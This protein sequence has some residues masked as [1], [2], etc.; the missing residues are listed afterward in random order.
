MVS[1]EIPDWLGCPLCHGHLEY[2]QPDRLICPIDDLVFPIKDDIIRLLPPDAQSSAEVLTAD[3]DKRRHTQ[4]WRRL[5]A[6]EMAVLP[7]QT[8]DDWESLYWH[9]RYQSF[10]RL[11][12]IVALQHVKAGRPLQIVDMGA[13]IGWLANQLAAVGHDVIALDISDSDAFG[14]AAARRLRAYSDSPFTLIQ[15]RLEHPPLR[16]KQV[17]ALNLQRKPA[18]SEWRPGL[19]VALPAIIIAHG[20][21]CD[22]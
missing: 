1:T 12:R 8:P 10:Q 5:D 7:A 15:G 18:L 9:V 22:P 19:L 3:Y 13:G 21:D 6:A 4:G 14:L 16:R 20:S 2:E 11:S 17:D